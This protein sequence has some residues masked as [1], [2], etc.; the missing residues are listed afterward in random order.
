MDLL[1]DVGISLSPEVD[2]GQI[3]G[4]YVMGLGLYTSEELVYDDNTGK[5][6]TNR[7][8][9]TYSIRLNLRRSLY[10]RAG[11][12][13]LRAPAQPTHR[14]HCQCVSSTAARVQVD[15]W[16]FSAPQYSH[17]E[18]VTVQ[19]VPP[20]Q[21]LKIDKIFYFQK[22]KQWNENMKHMWNI[23]RINWII[24]CLYYTVLF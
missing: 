6:L 16:N 15:D 4:A 2:I 23:E 7:T 12:Q 14:S 20:W 8:W 1:E 9:V 13:Q 24:V 19:R 3:E 17:V 18:L 22:T 5:I 10:T 21:G 11:P